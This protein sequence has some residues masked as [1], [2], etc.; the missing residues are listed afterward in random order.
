MFR[1]LILLIGLTLF[2]SA[3]CTNGGESAAVS[4]DSI[5]AKE[6]L[7]LNPDADIFQYEG[8]IYQTNIDWVN[9]LSLKKDDQIGEIQSRNE[10]DTDFENG[11]SNKLPVGVKIFSA[12]ERRDILLVESEGK[13]LKYLAIVEG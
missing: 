2:T 8:V 12:K 11:M 3:G 5:D 13:V 6:V 4:I 1:N 10:K 7:R 9:E